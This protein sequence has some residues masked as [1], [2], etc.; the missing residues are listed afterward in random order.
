[1]PA[2][3]DANANVRREFFAGEV[4]GAADTVYA[5]FRSF[6]Q[7]RL[8]RVHAIVTT[9]GADENHKLDVYQGTTSVA[10]LALGTADKGS[11]VSTG[12]IDQVIDSMEKVSVRTGDD[13][14]G[15]A[16][17]V[18]EFETLWDAEEAPG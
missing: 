1:M 4:G 10:T 12:S 5:K 15:L 13:A 18:I 16:D 14:T 2:Y 9:P 7:I 6:M 8:L 11:R 17:V 3:T